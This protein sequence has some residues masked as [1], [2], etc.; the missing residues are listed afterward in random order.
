MCGNKYIHASRLIVIGKPGI[1][2]SLLVNSTYVAQA[3]GAF[4]YERTGQV[5]V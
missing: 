4:G 5:Q 2:A 1:R 3:A